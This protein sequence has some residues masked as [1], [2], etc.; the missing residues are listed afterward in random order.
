MDKRNRE[1]HQQAQAVRS[2]LLRWL[3]RSHGSTHILLLH[4]R[5]QNRYKHRFASC[6]MHQ[7]AL[8]SNNGTFIPGLAAPGGMHQSPKKAKAQGGRLAVTG[9][10]ARSI[11]SKLVSEVTY[12]IALSFVPPAWKI[13][14]SLQQEKKRSHTDFHYFCPFPS[15]APPPP[16]NK[17][18][19]VRQAAV[20]LQQQGCTPHCTPRAPVLLRAR[21]CQLT[22]NL[23]LLTGGERLPRQH[24]RDGQHS[25][26]A[27]AQ[28]VP[29]ALPS[30]WLH[31]PLAA[32][33][34]ARDH[35]ATAA[36]TQPIQ[37]AFQAVLYD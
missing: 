13:Q 16:L 29:A 4:V 27:P 18:R 33:A 17:H 25:S 24:C 21:L 15:Y 37:T 28:S 3:L 6:A 8:P 7:A 2:Q 9:E 31:A 19:Q 23:W 30:A 26:P 22:A 10:A 36:G 35:T 1:A 12:R 34:S 32:H 14:F 20:M 5:K 11:S